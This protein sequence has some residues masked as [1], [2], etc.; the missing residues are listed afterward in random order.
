MSKKR[1]SILT[2]Q[3]LLSMQMAVNHPLGISHA[4]DT[5]IKHLMREQLS[6]F[7]RE[8]SKRKEDFFQVSLTMLAWFFLNLLAFIFF[9]FYEKPNFCFYFAVCWIN[10]IQKCLTNQISRKSPNSTNQNWNTQKRKK[11]TLYPRKKVSINIWNTQFSYL[12]FCLLLWLLHYILA[13]LWKVLPADQTCL[14]QTKAWHLKISQWEIRVWTL[15]N[16]CFTLKNILY[17]T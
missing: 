1:R 2:W 15:K 13:R 5:P 17:H 4:W 10:N 6:A 3:I 9:I 11:R 16:V 7:G 12:I 8:T 14:G